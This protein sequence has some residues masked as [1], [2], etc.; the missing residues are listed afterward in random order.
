MDGATPTLG[1]ALT[2]VLD[3]AD[4]LPKRFQRRDQTPSMSKA[5]RGC[6]LVAEE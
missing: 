2:F 1:I 3:F 4:A 6:Y 5:V